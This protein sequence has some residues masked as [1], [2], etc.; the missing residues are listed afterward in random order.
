MP[1]A[2]PTIEERLASHLS[3][4]ITFAANDC[5]YCGSFTKNFV[6]AVYSFFL[7]AKYE[8]S[9]EVYTNWHQAMNGPF[10]DEYC[11]AAE[12]EIITFEGMGAWDVAEHEDDMNVINGTCTFKFK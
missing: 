3:K 10:A 1:I 6:T 8:A 9:K 11:K 12:E 5:G 2:P 4:F 7:K